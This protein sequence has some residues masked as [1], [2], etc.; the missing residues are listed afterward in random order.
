MYAQQQHITTQY[1]DP[2]PGQSLRQ[3][4]NT[5]TGPGQ[6]RMPTGR[7]TNI[8]KVW[9]GCLKQSKHQHNPRPT[10]KTQK[11]THNTL[12]RRTNA[13]HVTR[14]SCVRLERPTAHP[15]RH[16]FANKHIYPAETRRRDKA[17]LTLIR[18]LRRRT[19]AKPASS[20]RQVSAG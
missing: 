20:Q 7:Y 10:Q 3:R 15:G 1:T 4:T 18:R 12:Q 2:V 11:K 16:E 8:N 19:N 5:K 9:G 6:Y 13:A 14:M 17:D